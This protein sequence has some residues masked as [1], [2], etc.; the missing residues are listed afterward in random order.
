LTA[1]CTDDF[2]WLNRA[3]AFSRNG[4][5]PEPDTDDYAWLVWA[6][7][8]QRVGLLSLPQRVALAGLPEAVRAVGYTPWAL[9][10]AECADRDLAGLALGGGKRT[11]WLTAQRRAHARGSLPAGRVALLERLDGFSWTPG[12]D[13]WDSAFALV[14]DFAERTGSIPVRGDDA[15]LSGW[16]AAQRFALRAGRLDA[17]RIAALESLPGWSASLSNTR[18]RGVWDRRCSALRSFVTETGRYPHTGSAD[19]R[20]AALARWVSTQRELYRRGDL[21][22]YRID[23]LAG[24]PGWRWGARE[25]DF[26]ARSRQ[27]CQELGGEPIGTDHRLYG[28][29]VSQRRRHRDGRLSDEQAAMLRSL[30]LLGDDLAATVAA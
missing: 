23:A 25:A 29:V 4:D 5:V 14:R 15:A 13:R 27:L 16:L 22:S 18:T 12:A 30:N 20:E 3:A 26:D 2:A 19:T 8:Q 28:W 9:R 10:Y 11:A 7:W 24:L 21:G 6:V 17:G 1:A